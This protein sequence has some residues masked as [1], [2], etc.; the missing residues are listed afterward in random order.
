C[1]HSLLRLRALLAARLDRARLRPLDRDRARDHRAGAVPTAGHL[2]QPG[3]DG[4]GMTAPIL[5][6]HEVTRSFGGL[7]AVDGASLDVEPGSITALIGPNGA[8]KSTLFNVVSGFLAA[9]RGTVR[10]DG[11]RI[12][13]SPP[14]RIARFGLVRT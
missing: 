9:D 12:D 6:V 1:R 4:A 3:G 14:H 2:R 11:R 5:E 8:G 13:R 7:R 10:F